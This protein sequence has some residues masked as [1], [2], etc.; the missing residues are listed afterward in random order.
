LV[1]FISY[2]TTPEKYCWNLI[3]LNST[4]GWT[5]NISKSELYAIG[6]LVFRHGLYTLTS[7]HRTTQPSTLHGT[8]K[9]LSASVLS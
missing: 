4:H 1:L 2:I 7:V 6:T 9:W 3:Q 5:G 8:V